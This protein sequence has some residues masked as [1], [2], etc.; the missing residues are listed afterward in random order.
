MMSG[1]GENGEAILA[2]GRRRRPGSRGRASAE[3]TAA[4]KLLAQ[5]NR[6]LKRENA[7]LRRRVAELEGAHVDA[8]QALRLYRL[9]ERIVRGSGPSE[10]GLRP[11]V[12][13]QVRR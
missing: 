13:Q 10:A 1:V 3:V 4:L 9:A 11:R 6:A 7:K 12:R 8:Q 5:E 2:A